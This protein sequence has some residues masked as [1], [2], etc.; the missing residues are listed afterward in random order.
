[1]CTF[2]AMMLAGLWL[3]W[4]ARFEPTSAPELGSRTARSVIVL[5]VV[6]VVAVV[7]C[8]VGIV[9]SPLALVTG[10]VTLAVVAMLVVRRR[11][12]PEE[13]TTPAG[14]RRSAFESVVLSDGLIIA[15]L[16]ALALL[17]PRPDGSAG[18][19]GW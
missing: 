1:L 7:L 9:A 6:A 13:A 8:A 2:A 16:P 5:R 19:P 11:H 17:R 3:R 4:R 14:P 15:T 12:H 18:A 10:V